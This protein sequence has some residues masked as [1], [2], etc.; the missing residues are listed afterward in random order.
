MNVFEQIG[1]RVIDHLSYVGGL[2]TQFWY[3]LRASPRVLPVVGKRGRWRATMRQVVAVGVDA[4]PTVAVMSVCAGFILALQAG[5]ELKRFGALQYVMDTVAIGFTRELGPLLTAFVVGG[6]SGS[7]FSAEI[8]TMTVT[9]E[10]DALRTMAVDPMEFV[11]AP[12][13][14]ATAIAVPCLTVM[15]NAFGL[16]AGWVFMYI[17]SKTPLGM[18]LRYCAESV[19]MHDI[20]TGI[21]KSIVFAGII[22]NVGCMEGFRTRGG[23]DAVGRSATSAVVRCTFLVIFADVFFTAL[24]Y[25]TKD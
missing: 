21:V 15:S 17:T 8:G 16:L 9:S 10:I 11:L 3:G 24:F 18:F 1:S 6:R 14:V 7:A 19:E 4:L 20:L 23:P 5:A 22:A 25:L 12:K 2:T 13:F